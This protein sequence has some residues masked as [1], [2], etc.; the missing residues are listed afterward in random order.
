MLEH[1]LREAPAMRRE[2]RSAY[3]AMRL[4]AELALPRAED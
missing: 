4:P 1:E 2:R 3:A